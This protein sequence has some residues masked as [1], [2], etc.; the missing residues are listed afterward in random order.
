MSRV[1]WALH[2]LL[3]LVSVLAFDATAALLHA[4]DRSLALTGSEVAY[5]RDPSGQLGINDVAADKLA[6]RFLS[7]SGR[8]SFGYTNDVIWLRITLQREWQAPAEWWLELT[9]PYIN[10]LRMYS[11]GDGGFAVRQCGDRY[12]FVEREISYHH[13]VFNVSL[14]DANPRT[15]YLRMQSDSSLSSELVLWRPLPCGTRPK[16]NCFGLAVYWA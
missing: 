11:P 7:M 10:D 5:L 16:S 9:N 3:A 13:P 12:P 6:T 14:L 4:N 15:F 8:S 2:W 1:R